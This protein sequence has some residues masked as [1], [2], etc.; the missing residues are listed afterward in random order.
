MLIRTVS[1][2]AGLSMDT[3]IGILF[4]TTFALGLAML[5]RATTIRVNMEDLLMGQILAMSPTDIYVSLAIAALV[6]LVLFALHNWL[7]FASFDP[8]GSQVFGK[9]TSFVDYVM[10]VILALVIVIGIQAAA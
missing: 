2:R 8:V 1:R 4:A 3:S 10:M 7:L 5:S 6:I 9:R